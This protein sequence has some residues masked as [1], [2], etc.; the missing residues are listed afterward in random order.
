M[1]APRFLPIRSAREFQLLHI[2]AN[3]WYCQ[4]VLAVDECVVVSQGGFNLHLPNP[5]FFSYA[6]YSIKF[7]LM[8][9]S[10]AL[11]KDLHA[12]A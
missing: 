2:L 8:K 1:A 3:T 7:C 5:K 12:L 10:A 4:S 6:Y 9:G 11:K